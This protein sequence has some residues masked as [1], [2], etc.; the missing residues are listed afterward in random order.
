MHLIIVTYGPIYYDYFIFSFND[1]SDF[2]V[3]A[4]NQDTPIFLKRAVDNSDKNM[5]NIFKG[6]YIVV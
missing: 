1:R 4:L 2:R 5:K 3:L 6:I